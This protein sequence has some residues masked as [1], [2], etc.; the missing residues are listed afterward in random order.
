MHST[1]ITADVLAGLAQLPDDSVHVVVTSPPYLTMKAAYGTVWL[2]RNKMEE[3]LKVSG[4]VLQRNLS[5]GSI[6]VSASRFGIRNGLSE[7]MLASNA[8]ALRLPRSL[9]LPITP[10]TSGSISTA[11]KGELYPKPE[12][13]NIGVTKVKVTRCMAGAEKAIPIGKADA[14]LKD[15]RNMLNLNGANLQSLSA[16]ETIT[17]VE[18]AAKVQRNRRISWTCIIS[19][20]GLSIQNYDSIL[21]ILLYYAVHVTSVHIKAKAEGYYSDNYIG[22]ELNPEYAEMSRRRIEREAGGLFE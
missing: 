12:R 17:N 2:C 15:K 20:D 6:G 22:V 19:K 8:L 11:L 4:E 16:K 3:L 7:N 13:L 1:I 14:P 21:L 9:V 10:Y 18:Y 5:Q